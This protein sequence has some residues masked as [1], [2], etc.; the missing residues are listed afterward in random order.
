MRALFEQQLNEIHELAH[1]YTESLCCT[2]CARTNDV[3]PFI[4]VTSRTYIELACTAFYIVSVGMADSI[5]M[6]WHFLF[7]TLRCIDE[8]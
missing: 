4:G 5:S 6:F 8:P 3:N 1:S 2:N 7:S